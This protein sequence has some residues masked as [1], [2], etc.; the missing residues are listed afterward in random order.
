MALAAALGAGGI[1]GQLLDR[2]TSPDRDTPGQIQLLRADLA[3]LRAE[4]RSERR[5]HREA[6]R[7]QR[8]RD[9]EQDR[10]IAA[11]PLQRNPDLVTADPPR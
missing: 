8:E 1:G 3:E 5:E 11:R 10:R 2:L 9:R 4:L 6:L 7:D